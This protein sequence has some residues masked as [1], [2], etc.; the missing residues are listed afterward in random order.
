MP[1]RDHQ[2]ER[3]LPFEEASRL[4]AYDPETG[5]LKWRVSPRRGVAVGTLAGARNGSGY[6]I[7]GY[8]GHEYMA[9][10][11]IW[12]LMTGH[13]PDHGVDHKSRDRSDDRW[14]NLRLATYSQNNQNMPIR[15]DNKTGVRGVQIA[16]NGS[17]YARI[18]VQG[19]SVRLGTFTSLEQAALVRQNAELKHFGKFSPLHE[20]R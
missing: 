2:K 13:W 17:F 8:R 12:L 15:K 1:K 6:V 10:H 4:L 14:E 7:V 3:F 5:V 9:T 18:G 20:V 16:R 11:L 19:R